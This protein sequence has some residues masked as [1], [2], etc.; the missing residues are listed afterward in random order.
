M[1]ICVLDVINT[2]IALARDS[3]VEYLIEQDVI[4][5]VLPLCQ[6]TSARVRSLAVWIIGNAGTVYFKNIV[7]RPVVINALVEVRTFLICF[8]SSIKRL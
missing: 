2:I 8:L 3:N 5:S 1:L 6:S 7:V 4:T